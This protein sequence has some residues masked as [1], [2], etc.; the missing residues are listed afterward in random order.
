[1]KKQNKTTVF[2]FVAVL[3]I[4]GYLIYVFFI[5]KTSI[6][7][8]QKVNSEIVFKLDK[9]IIE[10]N[11]HELSLNYA[12]PFLKKKKKRV[13]KRRIEKKVI[14]K[15]KIRFPN[16]KYD[17]YIGN[18]DNITFFLISINQ[19]QIMFKL[20]DIHE[21]VTLVEGN[22]QKVIISYQEEKKEIVKK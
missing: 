15:K 18:G 14:L 22:E 20:N 3:G 1:M 9:T 10:S 13:V 7:D 19:K 5:E 11:N 12:D 21:D 16:I 2:L 6:A 4:W 17:G 8:H